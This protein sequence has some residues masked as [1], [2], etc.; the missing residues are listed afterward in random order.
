M[1]GGKNGEQNIFVFDK[2]INSGQ[3][4]DVISDFQV[5]ID[6]IQL[7][8]YGT[9]T[10]VISND[11]FGNALIMLNSGQQIQLLGIDPS[12]VQIGDFKFS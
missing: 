10:P 1:S 8:N 9:N 4:Y 7:L 2:N 12:Q 6:K 3:E 11:G 5:G